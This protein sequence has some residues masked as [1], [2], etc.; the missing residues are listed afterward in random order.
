MLPII[1]SVEFQGEEEK[2]VEQQKG[3]GIQGQGK[4]RAI[5]CPGGTQ[6]PQ[7]PSGGRDDEEQ[8]ET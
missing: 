7:D 8:E 2:T 4:P 5:T 1:A 3:R 6:I